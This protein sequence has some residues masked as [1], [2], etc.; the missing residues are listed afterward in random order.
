MAIWWSWWSR[1][2]P[3]FVQN[4]HC[5]IW[6]VEGRGRRWGEGEVKVA[7]SC[8]ILSYCIVHGILQARI[9]EWVAFPFSRGSSQPRNQTQVFCIVGEFFTSWATREVQEYW[10]ESLS[11][12]QGIFPTQGSNWALLQCRWILY[13]LSY[14]GN[15]GRRWWA[16]IFICLS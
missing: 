11:L 5:Y 2:M 15:P 4:T 6:Q 3:L 14:E 16:S 9:L 12:L 8:L 13:Q 7:Q 1:R 10:R